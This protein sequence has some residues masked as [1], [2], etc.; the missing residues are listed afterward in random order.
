VR[1]KNIRVIAILICISVVM[2]SCS[3]QVEEIIQV[4]KISLDAEELV[5]APEDTHNFSITIEP[6]EVKPENIQLTWESSNPDIAT[7]S[8]GE[9][10]GRSDGTVTIT[11]T[12]LN[13]VSASCNVIVKEPSAYDKLHIADKKLY[14]IV[15]D[16]ATRFANPSS[17]SVKSVYLVDKEF[18]GQSS[19]YDYAIVI[20][21]MNGFG[22]Y[23]FG[24]INWD[25]ATEYKYSSEKYFITDEVNLYDIG[26]VNDAIGEYFSE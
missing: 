25:G 23:A 22:G 9:L 1:I 2:I 3:S 4:E 21:G 26:L 7:I 11:V 24:Y 14:N 19:C 13:G 5:I 18:P 6:L 12:N 16:C 20:S 10:I 8:D 17:I 15:T